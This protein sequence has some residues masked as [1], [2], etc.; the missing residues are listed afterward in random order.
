[1]YPIQKNWFSILGLTL[2]HSGKN[3][4]HTEPKK[5][6]TFIIIEGRTASGLQTCSS[7]SNSG[8]NPK[9]CKCDLWFSVADSLGFCST[10]KLY[11]INGEAWAKLCQKIQGDNLHRPQGAHINAQ[12]LVT[13][14]F[15][16]GTTCLLFGYSVQGISNIT[17]VRIG[18]KQIW[19]SM[20]LS[21]IKIWKW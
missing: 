10:R 18:V 3:C 12:T 17:S 4:R 15:Q 9:A 21:I 20:V 19:V 1:M 14:S 13:Y 5:D 7:L 8:C 11:L 6:Y 16:L 2:F